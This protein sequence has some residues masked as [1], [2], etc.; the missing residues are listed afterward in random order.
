MKQR[1]TF[2]F[3]VLLGCSFN[4][5]VLA[6]STFERWAVIASPKVQESGLADLVL[7]EVTKLMVS[8]LSTEHK[9]EVLHVC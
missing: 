9:L 6:K 4:S 5:A 8:S 7:A 3:A 1:L 2:V